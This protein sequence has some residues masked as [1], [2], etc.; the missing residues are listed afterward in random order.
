MEYI[1]VF[2]ISSEIAKISVPDN[3]ELSGTPDLEEN[4]EL[5]GVRERVYAGWP[6]RGQASYC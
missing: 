2:I 5:M 6:H 3:A 1:L 4:G